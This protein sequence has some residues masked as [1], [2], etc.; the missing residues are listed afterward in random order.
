MT[1]S[2]NEIEALCKRAARG[3]A[4]SWGVSEEA[5]KAVRWLASHGVPG[6]RVFADYL[7]KID[8]NDNAP[9]APR[10][11]APPWS[12]AS[13]AL[14]PLLSGA[15]L[16]DSVA[17]LDP[18]QGMTLTNVSHP[19]LFVPFVAWAA[20]SENTVFSVSWANTKVVTDGF[21]L[22]LSDAQGDIDSTAPADVF[23]QSASPDQTLS[24]PDFRG[25]IPD[26]IWAALS[27]YAHRTYAPATEE[28]RRLGAG[29]GLSDND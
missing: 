15:A 9:Q 28:S 21:S 27:A 13:G 25:D 18:V 14:C 7:G 10:T 17:M 3:V 19:L 2:L 24:A 1:R 26:D 4:L 8:S 29:A 11:L 22:S 20:I 23:W 5:A 6:P 16:N 12:A